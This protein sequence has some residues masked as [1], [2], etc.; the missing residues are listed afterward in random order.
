MLSLAA[1]W[2]VIAFEC[3][4]PASVLLGAPGVYLVLAV[5]LAFHIGIAVTMGLNTFLRAFTSAYP[6]VVVLAQSTALV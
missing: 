1:C 4:A 5:G 6:A 3:L 2:S